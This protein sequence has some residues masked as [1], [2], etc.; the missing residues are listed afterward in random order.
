[1]SDINGDE[2]DSPLLTADAGAITKVM[3][4]IAAAEKKVGW[5]SGHRVDLDGLQWV[6]AAVS[7]DLK[8]LLHITL[9]GSLAKYA[10]RRLLQAR[11][12][13]FRIRVALTTESLFSEE[14]ILTLAE[15]DADVYVIDD[16]VRKWQTKSRHVMAALADLQIPVTILARKQVGT[17]AWGNISSGTKQERGRRLEAFLAFLLSQVSDLRVV[18]R[19]YRN[20]SQEIDLVL[21]VDSLSNR[22]WQKSGTPLLLVEAKN[23]AARATQQMVSVLIQKLQT[24]RTSTRIGFLVSPNGFTADAKLE[25]LR[26]S[27]S[28]VCVVMIDGGD[29]LALI[30]A[31]D[32]DECLE[33]LV[34]H[35][36]LR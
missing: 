24:K 23:T 30:G 13:G 16:R 7:K 32:L 8:T 25:E 10:R 19:N 26:S 4:R 2:R 15:V 31:E 6:P 22:V 27:R 34:R 36:L 29:V 5:E 20:A 18:E 28:E 35:A 14:I 11:A 17:V 1:M 12:Q 9:S 3:E 33:G 21:Q